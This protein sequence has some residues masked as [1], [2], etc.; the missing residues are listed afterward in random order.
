MMKKFLL[1]ALVCSQI[2]SSVAQTEIRLYAD[3]KTDKWTVRKFENDPLNVRVYTFNNG[4]QLLTSNQNKEP[5]IYTM[6]AVKTGSA[7]D[8]ADH[9]GLAHYLEHMLF[10][11]TDKYGTQDWDKEKAHLKT[12]DE[13][14]DKYNKTLDETKRKGLYR[15]IDS[16]SQLAAKFSIANEYDKMCQAMGASGTNAFTSL[17]QTCYINEIPSNKL[18]QWIELESERYRNPILRLFHT[19]LEA[20]YEEKNISLDND[21][22]KVYEALNAKLYPGHPYGTQTTIG[23]IEHLKNPSLQAIRDYYKKYYVANNMAIIMC[24]DFDPDIAADGIAEHF[25]YMKPSND[26]PVAGLETWMPYGRPEVMEI[27]GPDAENITIGYRIERTNKKNEAMLKVMDLLLS[28]SAAGLIDVNLVQTQAVQA[29]Y[30]YPSIDNAACALILH[31]EPKEG[32]TLEQVRDL[33]VQQIEAIKAGKFDE[34]S[35]K[36]IILNSDIDQIKRFKSNTSRTYFLMEAFISGKGYREQFNGLSEMAKLSKAE[37]VAFANEYFTEG[38]VEIYKRIGKDPNLVKVDKPTINP[39]ELNRDKQSGFVKNWLTEESGEIAQVLPNFSLIN[40]GTVDGGLKIW[41]VKNEENRMF[42]ISYYYEQGDAHNK[43]WSYAL[44][45]LQLAGSEKTTASELKK[46]LYNIG[47]SVNMGSGDKNMYIGVDGPEESFDKALVILEEWISTPRINQEVL[48][49]IVANELKSRE[50]A[51]LDPR[52]VAS[53]LLAYSMYG[54][55]NQ[56]TDI[57]SK[58]ALNGLKAKDLAELIRSLKKVEHHVEYFGE[59]NMAKV[60]KTVKA[61][62]KTD[63]FATSPKPVEYELRNVKEK[64]VYF[65]HYEQVQASIYWYNTTYTYAPKMATENRAFNTYFGGDMSSVVFQSIRESKALAYSTYAS[66]REANEKNKPNYNI[67][68]IGTQA[69]KFKDAVAG[70]NELISNLPVDEETFGLAK[71]SIEIDLRTNRV[72]PEQL[73]GYKRYFEKKGIDNSLSVEMLKEISAVSMK[74][75]A[76]FHKKYW[77]NN[78]FAMSIVGDKAKLPASELEKYGKLKVLSLED[79]FGY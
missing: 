26:L 74:D 71:K 68:F 72:M 22:S 15:Q 14:Y 61:V 3:T 13:L 67:A 53:R 42:N 76:G 31:G 47:C 49:G 4:L 65:T 62:H 66:S 16:V 18:H 57:L 79:I 9:T 6:V 39:V 51:K 7:N 43:L 23:T 12:I 11:G 1:L 77:A 55:K 59:A 52:T 69:D 25:G 41:H 19:E 36:A 75:V 29:A 10:K 17:D 44:Q 27:L 5:R 34:A 32:Q 2:I 63:P 70:M 33:L 35:L 56:N 40:E 8:P 64:E 60:S 46:Q 20:V 28:N 58:T 54:P 78:T 50:N 24:G 37:I 21:N 48:D 30:S 38:R 45:Y 73:M